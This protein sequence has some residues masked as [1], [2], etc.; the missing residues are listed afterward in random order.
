MINR[1]APVDL[2]KDFTLG[3]ED[4]SVSD[5]ILK[6]VNLAADTEPLLSTGSVVSLPIIDLSVSAVIVSSVVNTL[7]TGTVVAAPLIYLLVSLMERESQLQAALNRV[8]NAENEFDRMIQ[9]LADSLHI[10]LPPKT[11]IDIV[12]QVQIPSRHGFNNDPIIGSGEYHDVTTSKSLSYLWTIGHAGEAYLRFRNSTPCTSPDVLLGLKTVVDRWTRD[13]S[14]G[15]LVIVSQSLFQRDLDQVKLDQYNAS[16]SGEHV[17]NTHTWDIRTYLAN[18]DLLQK[19]LNTKNGPSFSIFVQNFISTH[20][21]ALV[22]NIVKVNMPYTDCL[23]LYI[24]ANNSSRVLYAGDLQSACQKL[25]VD[26]VS[27]HV[28]AV[29]SYLSESGRYFL[30]VHGYDGVSPAISS[31]ATDVIQGPYNA[32]TDVSRAD[33]LLLKPAQLSTSMVREVLTHFKVVSKYNFTPR[34]NTSQYDSRGGSTVCLYQTLQGW[35]LLIKTDTNEVYHLQSMRDAE[36]VVLSPVVYDTEQPRTIQIFSNGNGHV[37]TLASN[38]SFRSLFHLVSAI[39]R[40]DTKAPIDSVAQYV[41]DMQDVP[42]FIN[43]NMHEH[44]FFDLQTPARTDGPFAKTSLLIAGMS[45]VVG[46]VFADKTRIVQ[47]SSNSGLLLMMRGALILLGLVAADSQKEQIHG[48]YSDTQDEIVT[49]RTQNL[50][51]FFRMTSFISRR[52]AEDKNYR[53]S[54]SL[55]DA[56][57]EIKKTLQPEDYDKIPQLI[58]HRD[59]IRA[60]HEVVRQE[61]YNN[62]IYSKTN[63]PLDI[64]VGTDLRGWIEGSTSLSAD[65]LLGPHPTRLDAYATPYSTWFYEGING[66]IEGLHHE[67]ESNMLY[68]LFR[69]VGSSVSNMDV[70]IIALGLGAS[71]GAGFMYLTTRSNPSGSV[72]AVIPVGHA[73]DQLRRFDI[74]P[75]GHSVLVKTSTSLKWLAKKSGDALYYISGAVVS[76]AGS[77]VQ[78][79]FRKTA[80]TSMFLAGYVLAA[81]GTGMALYTLSPRKR[82]RFTAW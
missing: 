21:H 3:L 38:D 52:T 77:G 13:I 80:S 26:D 48:V 64:P 9:E 23:L 18:Y 14:P 71:V 28:H 44:T 10:V 40:K 49:A 24:G 12:Y 58:A 55:E 37:V 30:P 47:T 56:L 76:G 39:S 78:Y 35:A 74:I 27:P 72:V 29:G 50:I 73:L 6:S 69:S 81:I 20:R 63:N 45:I 53:I 70:D 2:W 67:A 22:K 57:S 8:I 1:F 41:P 62:D 25:N 54:P 65:D 36:C 15:P 51:D 43:V 33:L 59:F 32:L 82:R 61:E 79:I 46:G 17:H 34:T 31:G 7:V 75:S 16:T 42:K 19:F 66:L 68:C 5:I 11:V 60:N 4:A